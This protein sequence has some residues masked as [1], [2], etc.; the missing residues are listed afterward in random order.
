MAFAALLLHYDT[1]VD[2]QIWSTD[3]VAKVGNLVLKRRC[4][5]G[6]EPYKDS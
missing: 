6:D 4:R 3:Y 5:K 2:S 1:M